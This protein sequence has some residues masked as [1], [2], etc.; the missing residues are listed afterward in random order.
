MIIDGL[1][2]FANNTPLTGAVGNVVIGDVVDTQGLGGNPTGV[3]G[4]GSLGDTGLFIVVKAT[5][6]LVAAGAGTVTLQL[7]SDSDPALAT[8]PTVHASTG[9]LT[10]GATSPAPLR[11]GDVIAIWPMPLATAGAPYERYLGVRGVIAGNAVSA[12]AIDAF[13]TTEAT[14]YTAYRSAS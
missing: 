12:G 8:S 14:R 9:A 10:T 1:L 2:T 11:T 13:V 4:A 7:V 6:A 5:T 3:G